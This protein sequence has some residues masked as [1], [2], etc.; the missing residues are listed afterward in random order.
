MSILKKEFEYYL[1]NQEQLVKAYNGK[2]LVIK[3]LE[4]KGQFDSHGDAYNFATANFELG[5]FII[6]HCLAGD[7]GHTQTFHSR[8]LVNA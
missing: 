1:E 2:F 8:V 3:D 5:T 6:Q 4:V 7:Q